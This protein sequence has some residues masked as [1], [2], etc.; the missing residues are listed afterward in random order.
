M[1]KCP[2]PGYSMLVEIFDSE[3]K[4]GGSRAAPPQPNHSISLQ[5]V[6]EDAEG[7]QPISLRSLRTPVKWFG[8]GR[9]THGH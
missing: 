8:R 9:W 2:L 4:R 3:F 7:L 6:A 1:T 5:E